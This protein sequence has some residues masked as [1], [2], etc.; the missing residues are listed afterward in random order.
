MPRVYRIQ[1]SESFASCHCCEGN[2]DYINWLS[3]RT[4]WRR[5]AKSGAL[6]HTSRCFLKLPLT[7]TISLAAVCEGDNRPNCEHVTDLHYNPVRCKM[8]DRKVSDCA[9]SDNMQDNW[10]EI[11]LA[12]RVRSR[13][14]AGA[15][16]NCSNVLLISAPSLGVYYFC[17]GLCLSVCLSVCL[18]QTLIL[19]FLFLDGIEPFLAVSSP[20]Q[21]LQNV[22]LRF[23]I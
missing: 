17:R 23:L 10:P 8:R 2:I 14:T 13:P 16:V 19:L 15:N 12:R 6:S 4:L 5:A 7:R 9:L 18:S 20:W 1:F 22:V 21:K 3:T 11:Y